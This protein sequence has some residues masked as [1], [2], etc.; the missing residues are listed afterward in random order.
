MTHALRSLRRRPLE[1][2]LLV[3]TIAFGVA[4]CGLVMSAA[5]PALKVGAGAPGLGAREI[6]VQ[7]RDEDWSQF[8]S[9]PNAPPV[10]R[11]GRVGDPKV[12]MEEADLARLKAAA[13]AVQA[14]YL[15]DDFTIGDFTKGQEVK[16][17]SREYWD[18]LGATLLTGALPS[19][20]EYRDKKAVLVLTE[21]GAGVLSPGEP[22]LGR[23]ISG[24]RVVGVV[25]PPGE[26]G[27]FRSPEQTQYG[28]LGLVPYGAT[29]KQTEGSWIVPQPLSTL[30]FLP[31]PGQDAAA[32]E[33]L[34]LAAQKRWG[35]RVS[36]GSNAQRMAQ[37]Q[38][39]YRRGA[40]ALTLLG[41]GGLL[42]AGL[43]VL[44]LMLA[45]VLSGQRQLGM[46][47]ALGA[48]RARLR[49]QHLTEAA[50]LGGLGSVLGG[51]LAAGLIWWLN[52]G[53]SGPFAGAL[54]QQ[55]PALLCTVAGGLLLSLLFGL[56]PAVQAAR[57]RPAEAL[58]A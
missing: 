28:A 34:G 49:A 11:V 31:R 44:A 24:Y 5:W 50:L 51:L 26:P 10:A 54:R 12:V 9:T 18:A 33:Q 6:T 23:T 27:Q 14:A 37:A 39:Q 7:S 53:V 45:R 13:P 48:S 3:L 52:R 47:A 16:M 4:L 17:V 30:R 42:L 55:P 21:Y 2:L 32:A 58:R 35:D 41:V 56:L 38:Q 20:A 36:V 19:A 57:V 22:A 29:V 43:S 46:A 1:S 25:R 40:L 15:S 8:Y